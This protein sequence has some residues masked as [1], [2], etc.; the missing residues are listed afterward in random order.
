M[1]GSTGSCTLTSASISRSYT[2]S[3]FGVGSVTGASLSYD[4]SKNAVSSIS[5]TR[6]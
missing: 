2:T 5:V 6:P 3:Q 4:A 1:T